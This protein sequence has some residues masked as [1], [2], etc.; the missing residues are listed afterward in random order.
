M[1]SLDLI[2]LQ[3]GQAKDLP[4]FLRKMYS[5]VLTDLASELRLFKYNTILQDIEMRESN[6][7]KPISKIFTPKAAPNEP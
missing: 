2:Q 4:L 6:P 3:N 1:E 5:N 7:V